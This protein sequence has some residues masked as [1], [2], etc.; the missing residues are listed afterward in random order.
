MAVINA[1]QHLAG[2]EPL[3]RLARRLYAAQCRSKY[4]AVHSKFHKNMRIRFALLNNLQRACTFARRHAGN[5]RR[6]RGIGV[7]DQA[8]QLLKLVFIY[9][10]D[11]AAYYALN[12]YEPPQRLADIEHYIGRQETKNGLYSLMR[13]AVSRDLPM[14][15]HSLASKAI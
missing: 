5:V 15:G 2:S 3:G 10:T 7:L 4:R 13:D 8:A 6:Q 1:T 12:L 14:T 9:R 11:P